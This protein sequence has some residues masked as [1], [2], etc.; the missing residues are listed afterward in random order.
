MVGR[1]SVVGIQQKYLKAILAGDLPLATRLVS[2]A[3]GD[4][5]SMT[6]I[7]IDIITPAQ[8]KVGD[9]WHQG[10]INV[11]EE[12]LATTI[13]LDV[14]NSMRSLTSSAS[15]TGLRAVVTPVE[16]DGHSVGAQMFSD[17]LRGDGW[18]VD[19]LAYPTPVD[20]LVAFAAEREHQLIAI[21]LTQMEFL[22]KAQATAHALHSMS[23]SLKVL[24]GG[25]ALSATQNEAELDDFDGVAG[26][27]VEGLQEARRLVGLPSAK[28][29][30]EEHL[31]EMGANIKRLRS[32][33]R[34]TQQ[35]LADQ[36]DMDRTYISM[37]E[38]GKQNLTMGALL[39]I[40]EALDIPLNEILGRDS[41][42]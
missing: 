8:S 39:R 37:V 4:G 7:Y 38:H 18:D 16:S 28:L 34:L 11:A 3:H 17:L 13:T 41:H 19:F 23:S 14:M 35:E 33:A 32:Q 42:S 31:L 15:R 26:N 12:H 2:D 1:K 20:D 29:T 30:L 24:L 36:S 9:M 27:A 22:T 40:A 21:S 25:F 5:V 6:S 10:S